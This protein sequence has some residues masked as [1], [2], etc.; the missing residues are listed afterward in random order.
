MYMK[1]KIK[2]CKEI[3]L[4]IYKNYRVGILKNLRKDGLSNSP[5]VKATVFEGV[6]EPAQL[7][8]VVLP[9]FKEQGLLI[10][11]GWDEERG[12][13][14]F[15]FNTEKMEQLLNKR[16]LSLGGSEDYNQVQFDDINCIL[17]CGDKKYKPQEKYQKTALREL[18]ENRRDIK[19]QKSGMRKPLA[20]FGSEIKFAGI[21]STQMFIKKLNDKAF[22]GRFEDFY[23]GISR[24]IKRAKITTVNIS[25]EGRG[26]L[27][28]ID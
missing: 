12:E 9:H 11:Y 20:S 19:T 2:A 26:I 21:D 23:K 4:R 22:N 14:D 28:I 18:W 27:M 13:L 15:T 1:G 17:S 8:Q 16:E 25:V 6:L 10:N 3:L 24:A 7:F 5:I